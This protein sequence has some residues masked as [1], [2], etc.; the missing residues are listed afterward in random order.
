MKDFRCPSCKKPIA[1]ALRAETTKIRDSMP[2]DRSV[3]FGEVLSLMNEHMTAMD[4]YELV[5]K[6]K[7]SSTD[8]VRMGVGKWKDNIEHYRG[9]VRILSWM[10]DEE[11]KVKDQCLKEKIP[12]IGTQ[13]L[14]SLVE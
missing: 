4:S 5:K 10:I 6:I 13:K 1:A 2:H 3:L 9:N 7:Y 8:A 14:R 12:V 11:E